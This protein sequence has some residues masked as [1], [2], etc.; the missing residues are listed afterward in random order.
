MS[1]NKVSLVLSSGGARGIA[2]ISIIESLLKEGY[3]IVEISGTSIG[4][5]V[6]AFYACGKLDKFKKWILKLDKIKTFSLMDFTVS[7]SGIIKGD[8][9]F[10]SLKKIIPDEKIENLQ[11]P[12]SIIATDIFNNKEVLSGSFSNI[13]TV[14]KHDSLVIPIF[15]GFISGQ[16]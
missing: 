7:Q 4:S 13:P 1:S 15:I 5:L 16:N 8:K 10:S 11:I 6:A 12:I 9:V 2:H 14:I 3:D